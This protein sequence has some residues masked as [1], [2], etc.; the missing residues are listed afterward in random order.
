MGKGSGPIGSIQA[1]CRGDWVGSGVREEA[2]VLFRAHRR[3]F[4]PCLEPVP[5]PL[6]CK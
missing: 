3:A 2:A 5:V 4:C 6:S 1:G